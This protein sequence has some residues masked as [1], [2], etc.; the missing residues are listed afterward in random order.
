MKLSDISDR[1]IVLRVIDGVAYAVSRDGAHVLVDNVVLR[2]AD[3]ERFVVDTDDE[4][5]V[6]KLPRPNWSSGTTA[7]EQ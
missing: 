1:W 2:V 5:E 6:V 4:V 7:T 3:G